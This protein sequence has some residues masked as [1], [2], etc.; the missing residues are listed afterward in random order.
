VGQFESH[1]LPMLGGARPDRPLKN[2]AL[3]AL[4]QGTTSQAAEKV[5]L[6]LAR[7]VRAFRPALAPVKTIRL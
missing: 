2:S 3:D 7:V 4:C 6:Y 5:D 1:A